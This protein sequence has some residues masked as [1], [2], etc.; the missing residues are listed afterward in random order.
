VVTALILAVRLA[1]LRA[2]LD[3]EFG[4]REYLYRDVA[5][6]VLTET[7]CPLGATEIGALGYYYPGPV[8]DFVGLVSPEVTR[9]PLP[10]VVASVRPCWI[11][12]YD[13]H[14]DPSLS[15]APAFTQHYA[16]TFRRRVGPARELLVFRRR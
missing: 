16:I 11:V 7:G 9:R 2:T 6:Q 13:T 12:S 14:L 3:R 15:T 5:E 8:L 4:E 1:P 10:D